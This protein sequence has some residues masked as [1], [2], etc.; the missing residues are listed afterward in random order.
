[1]NQ[2]ISIALASNKNVG[3]TLLEALITEGFEISLV[4]NLHPEHVLANNIAGYQDLAP[5]AKSKGIPVYRPRKYTLK[6]ELDEERIISYDIDLLICIGWQRLIP[7]WFLKSLSYGS[8]GMHG[9]SDFLPNGRGRSPMNW[10]LIE[11]KK[12]FITHLIRHDDGVD[13]GNIIDYQFFDINIWDD[14]ESLHYKNTIAEI[15]LLKR[16]L[17]RIMEE[18]YC[19]RQQEGEP[20]YEYPKRT[21]EHGIIDWSQGT[22]ELYNFIRAQTH[23]FPGAFSYLI[24]NDQNSKVYFWN[25]QPFDEQLDF[26]DFEIGQVTMKMYNGDF[27]VK[28]IDGSLLV[29]KYDIDKFVSIEK[30]S[31]FSSDAKSKRR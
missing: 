25:A 5:F 7:S 30:G 3:Q 1:M 4:I 6:D 27:I 17:P 16:N 10:C 26:E 29:R 15:N 11:N 12:R 31:F 19:G 20:E 9:S 22:M 28:T 18:N 23:P 14:I 24:S 13:S 8:Y 21:P 2:K